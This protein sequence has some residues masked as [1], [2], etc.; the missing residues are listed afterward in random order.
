VEAREV[1]GNFG[2]R[3]RNSKRNLPHLISLLALVLSIDED[4]LKSQL[5][6]HIVVHMGR[7]WQGGRAKAGY[8]NDDALFCRVEK[9]G[10]GHI[11][12]DRKR[13]LA[14][15]TRAHGVSW[16]QKRGRE[17]SNTRTRGCYLLALT[18]FGTDVCAMTKGRQTR[19]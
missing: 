16:G 7:A 6:V 3:A 9:A 11:L 5:V 14:H 13:L 8:P 18:D 15:V 12:F 1:E 4:I 19:N 10:D 2:S 17:Y